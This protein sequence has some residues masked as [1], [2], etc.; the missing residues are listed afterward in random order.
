MKPFLPHMSHSKYRSGKQGKAIETGITL[1]FIDK[2]KAI[3]CNFLKTYKVC[4]RFGESFINFFLMRDYKTKI[5]K[6]C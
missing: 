6:F 5:S 4:G 2:K 1:L 3:P